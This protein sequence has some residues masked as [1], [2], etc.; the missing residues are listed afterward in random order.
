MRCLYC[1]D[2]PILN[3][4][5]YKAPLLYPIRER[6][7]FIARTPVPTIKVH[8]TTQQSAASLKLESAVPANLHP[9]LVYLNGLS[10][11]SV[12]TM[13]HALDAIAQI[14]TDKQCDAYSLDWA[15]LRYPHTA[16]V[17]GALKKKFAPATAKK[18][19]C[20][21]RRTLKEAYK[22]GLMDF[23]DYVRATDLESIDT[24]PTKRRGRA[25]SEEE[26]AALMDVCF[27]SKQ[28][29]IDI[30]DAALIAILRGGGLRR[31][32][33]VRLKIKD[34]D[35]DTGALEIYKGKRGSY[36]TVY[37]PDDAIGM[38]CDWLDV[39]S[40]KPGPLLCHVRKG[41]IIELRP[42]CADSILKILNRRA[43]K[44]GVDN[45]SP[46]DF[47]RT[48]CSDLLD[49]G[50]DIATVQKLAGHSSPAVTSKYDRREEE[51]LRKAVQ[52]LSIPIKRRK[53]N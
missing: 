32:E 10:E 4:E 12:S 40:R 16:A 24:P 5:T 41:G 46:H 37:L 17:R 19:L 36:R 13:R 47:R 27:Q 51:T 18:M 22:L 1:R 8:P 34:F 7:R 6:I 30:R 20:A 44:A 2:I 23:E 43:E 52:K 26:I 3:P 29:L 15:K 53:S 28:S 9:A 35:A 21:L 42:L 25:L 33:V 14:L 38:V 11:G 48:F 39:R 50:V 45:F 49:A 31:N